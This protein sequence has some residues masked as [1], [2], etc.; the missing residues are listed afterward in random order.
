VSPIDDEVA[1][2]THVPIDFLPSLD[3]SRSGVFI[4]LSPL[5]NLT[6]LGFRLDAAYVTPAT[7]SRAIES[8]VSGVSDI[9]L[10]FVHLRN[11][12]EWAPVDDAIAALASRSLRP[13]QVTVNGFRSGVGGSFGYPLK[14]EDILPKVTSMGLLQVGNQD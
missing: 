9:Q 1:T 2:V 5:L 6:T 12:R 8:A 10:T 14:E 7:V 13:L 3:A 4:D 11:I